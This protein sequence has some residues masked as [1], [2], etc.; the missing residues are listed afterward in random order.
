MSLY[1]RHSMYS[2]PPE[3]VQTATSQ[4]SAVFES[5]LAALRSV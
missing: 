3:G 2:L 4:R 1:A 5:A